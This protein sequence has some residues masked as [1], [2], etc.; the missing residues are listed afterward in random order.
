MSAIVAFRSCTCLRIDVQRI[1]W[2]SL[3]ARFASDTTAIIKIDNPIVAV[4][5]CRNRADFNTRR[6]IAVVAPHHRKQAPRMRELALFNVFD[7]RAVYANGHIVFRFARNRTRVAS[8]AATVVN[9]KSKIRQLAGFPFVTVNC[10]WP[11]RYLFL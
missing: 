9:D 3:H 6:G 2:T 10:C 1:I 7:P 8:N 4:K 11:L 5:Q